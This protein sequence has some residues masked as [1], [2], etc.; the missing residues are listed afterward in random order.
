[1]EGSLSVV[2]SLM[3]QAVTPT[4]YRAAPKDTTR[5]AVSES[6]LSFARGDFLH[7][8][9]LGGW[10]AWDGCRFVPESGHVPYLR[11]MHYLDH[12]AQQGEDLKDGDRRKEYQKFIR[13]LSTTQQIAGCVKGCEAMLHVNEAELD[14]DPLALNVRNGWIDLRT[15]EFHAHSQ[16]KPFTKV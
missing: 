9:K 15:Q 7:N 6:F 3:E 16:P 5:R 12:L 11:M 8:D 1:R 13:S 2:Q 14:A 4:E 10:L